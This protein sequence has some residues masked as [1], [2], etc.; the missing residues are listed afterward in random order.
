M[1]KRLNKAQHDYFDKIDT[2]YKAY[3]LGFIYADGC[4]KN[5]INGRQKSLHISIQEEDGYILLPLLKDIRNVDKYLIR[6]PPSTIKN[7]W[8]KQATA[9]FSS[10][11][12][13]NNLIN[14]GC[15]IRKS[16]V[17]M[18]FPT[19]KDDMIN[20]F[21]RGFFDGDGSIAVDILKN[22]YVR[23]KDYKLKKPF[24]QKLRK[25][26]FF[27]S[28]D[29]TFLNVII[30]TLTS[31]LNLTK[32]VHRRKTIKQ[33][34]THT[35][36]FESLL[37]VEKI[38]DYLYDNATFYLKRKKDKFYETISSQAESKLSDGSETT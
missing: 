5:G 26:L 11:Q 37:E 22:R 14:Y 29:E 38:R 7:G 27:I 2:E 8:K 1:K 34:I 35:I 31:K 10:N 18:T 16:S 6:N 20:H 12:I 21:I 28:T 23:K 30:D 13:C 15:N 24:S 25:R 4:V 19:L 32:K 9:N 33:N 3:I 17:G 36:S